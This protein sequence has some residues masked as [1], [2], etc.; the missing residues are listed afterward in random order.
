MTELLEFVAGGTV[1]FVV[2]SWIDGMLLDRYDDELLP[3]RS[4]PLAV[5]RQ[6]RRFVGAISR[7][8]SAG[9]SREIV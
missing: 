9:S 1:M 5:V 7:P 8:A 4:S 3:S 6:A 2:L